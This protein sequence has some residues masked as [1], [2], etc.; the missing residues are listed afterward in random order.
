LAKGGRNLSFTIEDP[1]KS[2]KNSLCVHLNDKGFLGFKKNF[3][4]A[5]HDANIR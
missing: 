3:S 4:T 1:R 2:K 5:E